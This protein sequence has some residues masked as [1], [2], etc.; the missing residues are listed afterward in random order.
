[1]MSFSHIEQ[2]LGLMAWPL[3]LCSVI[4]VIL[5]VDRLVFIVFSYSIGRNQVRHKLKNVKP[6]AHQELTA[7]SYELSQRRAFIYQGTGV[8][9]AQSQVSKVLREDIASIWL[10]EKRHRL[11]SGLKVLTLIGVISPLLGLLGT[12]LGLIDM[13]KG[14]AASSGN[15]TPNDLAEGLGLAMR[16]TA[17]GLLIALPAIV[18][19]QLYT[20]WTERILARTEH[21]MNRINLWLEGVDLHPAS[22]F[23]N[24]NKT[25][26]SQQVAND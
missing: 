10:Q 13:F 3:V 21:A 22:S 4:T 23:I 24:D 18:A 20:L 26:S 2:Q 25:N 1:M 12:V 11:Q 17:A 15:I 7:L 8:L 9:L 16:T 14:V 19:A 5:V 6:S